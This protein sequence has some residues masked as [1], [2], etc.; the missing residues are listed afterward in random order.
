MLYEVITIQLKLSMLAYNL[1]LEEFPLA[2][3]YIEVLDKNNYLLTTE[4]GNFIGVGRFVLGLADEI[5][6]VYPKEFKDYLNEKM[7]KNSF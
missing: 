7:K 2:E 3:K 4:V 5:E 1:L 6:V